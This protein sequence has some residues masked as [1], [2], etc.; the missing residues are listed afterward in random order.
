MPRTPGHD[1]HTSDTREISCP[2]V[3]YTIARCDESVLEV[4]AA[5][6]PVV[7]TVRGAEGVSPA[8]GGRASSL[9]YRRIVPPP[10]PKLE[11]NMASGALRGRSRG[12]GG[13]EAV[14]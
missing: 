3:L 12:E 13:T 10:H 4:A 14:Q 6:E 2:A 7:R 9:L 8:A 1:P 5:L 11:N